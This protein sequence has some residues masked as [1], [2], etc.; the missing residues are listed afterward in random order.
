LFAVRTLT[1]VVTDL[2]TEFGVMVDKD[3]RVET[4]VF[5]GVV[6]VVAVR[7]STPVGAA[8]ELRQGEAV[9][10]EPKQAVIQ[11]MASNSQ[12]FVRRIS[13][14]KTVRDSFATVRDYMT[15]GVAGTVWHGIMNAK[16]AS[17][18]DTKPVTIDG[19]SYASQLVLS[20][21]ANA[22]AGWSE[23]SRNREFHNGPFLY[24]NVPQ[25]DFV[26]KVKIA[27]MTRSN[28]STCGLMALRD[29]NNFVAVNRNQHVKRTDFGIRSHKDGVDAD[30]WSTVALDANKAVTVVRLVRKG[31]AFFASC[32]DDGG[33]TWMAL[34]WKDGGTTLH[35]S[36]MGGEL[37][38]GLW[39]GTFMESEGT[40]IF[41]DFSVRSIGSED[42]KVP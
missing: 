14:A 6:R 36:D 2:G 1:A 34:D 19:V 17:R 26:A 42:S 20:V 41:Q 32:S 40:A 24:V 12:A 39:Y 30:R 8:Q 22:I 16:S 11:T 4:Q 3:G 5:E 38:V 28:F 37:R 29:E 35:R 15:D 18:I 13:D 10:I 21:P 25:G 31:D 23:P 9:R 7:N 27:G 33:Q